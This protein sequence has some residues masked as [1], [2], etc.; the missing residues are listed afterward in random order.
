MSE[1]KC[2]ISLFMATK[3]NVSEGDVIYN[4]F[5]LY[6]NLVALIDAYNNQTDFFHRI[7]RSVV[8]K[9]SPD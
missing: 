5:N 8:E 9:G 1:G 4:R 6:Q 7:D 3:M 2:W